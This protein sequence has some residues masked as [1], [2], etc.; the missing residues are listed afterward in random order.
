MKRMKI[1]GKII[2]VL[3]IIYF[4]GSGVMAGKSGIVFDTP[5]MVFMLTG[6]VGLTLM[7]FSLRE[8]GAAFRHAFGPMDGEMDGE[9]EEG[10]KIS[11]YF[12][13]AT[14]R[15][16][17]VFGVLGTVMGYIIV[18]NNHSGIA[19]YN[20]G[21]AVSFLTTLYGLILAAL[22]GVPALALRKKVN[23]KIQRAPGKPQ[24]MRWETIP[25]GVLFIG[26]IAWGVSQRYELFFHLPSL[27][28]VVGLALALLAL[29]GDAVAGHSVTLS[30]AFT[31]V[32]GVFIGIIKY[33]SGMGGVSIAAV[34][35]GV[36]FSLLSCVFALLGMLLAGMPMEDRA[37]KTGKNGTGTLLSRIAWYGFPI[38]V[39]VLILFTQIMAMIPIHKN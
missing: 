18:I 23:G 22:C 27:L 19:N 35:E 1:F 7:G 15:N 36:T 9:N 28:V 21:T 17:L 29:L 16:L 2:F 24:P 31:G 6:I 20:M 39:L 34:V 4:A 25:G 5:S 10:L 33:L 38:L 11:A 8:T 37:F 30:F 32:I 26:T 13:E 14:A 12:W 3:A